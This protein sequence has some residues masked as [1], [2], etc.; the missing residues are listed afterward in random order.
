MTK[1]TK[2]YFDHGGDR[3]VVDAG[4]SA[5][6][7][8]AIVGAGDITATTALISGTTIT[9][10]TS[11]LVTTSAVVGTTLNVVG[12]FSVNTD[13]LSIAAAT[14]VITLKNAAT[15]D[16][17]AAADTLKLTHTKINLVGA[18]T[19]TGALAVTGILSCGTAK[20]SVAPATG[21]L[22]L[23]NAMTIDGN[24][25]SDTIRLGALVSVCN[26]GTPITAD[27]PAGGVTL[28]WNGTD[29]L[30]RNGAGGTYTFTGAWA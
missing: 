11:L 8:G 15:I 28:Y 25:G 16:N 9:A 5:V 3:I 18:T 30:L 20:F 19:N 17:N 4:G 12:A 13:K 10:G 27:V 22:T 6:W 29:L 26:D 7:S 14:G 24:T 2:I 21:I 1:T 23:G